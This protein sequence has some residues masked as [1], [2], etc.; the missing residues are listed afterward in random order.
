MSY[1]PPADTLSVSW[2][3]AQEYA[4]PQSGL[5]PSWGTTPVLGA[6]GIAPPAMPQ[7]G[8]RLA[9]QFAADVSVA[10]S[11]S[12]VG[13]AHIGPPDAYVRPQN[14]LGG[15]WFGA[16]A[17][18]PPVA[19]LQGTWALTTY[20][21]PPGI[22]EGDVSPPVL[23]WQQFVAPPGTDFTQFGGSYALHPWQYAPPEWTL[24][25]T[26]VGAGA[27]SPPAH[28][29]VNG[30]WAL[31]AESVYVSTVGW[32]S[33]VSGG[34]L[35][36]LATKY[37]SPAGIPPGTFGALVFANGS[38]GISIGG[39]NAG[40]IGAPWVSFRT[41][42]LTPNG[43]A[44]PATQTPSPIVTPEV[45]ILDLAGRGIASLATGTAAVTHKVREV[46]P[47]FIAQGGFGSHLIA[48]N[49]VVE[50]AGWESSQPGTAHSV[51]INLQRVEPDSGVS[52]P[53]GYGGTHV[54]NQHEVVYPQGWASAQ[55]NAH[56]VYNQTQSVVVGPFA[57]NLPPTQW[58]HY[59][60]YVENRHR[61]LAPSGWSSSK[62]SLIGTLI[63]NGAVPI[64][65]DG[66]DATLWGSGTFIAHRVRTV[67]TEG[68]EEFYAPRYTAVYNS[69]ALLRLVGIGST[70]ACG[71]PT[72]ANLNRTVG[73]F[74]PSGPEEVGTPTIDFA[75]RTLHPGEFFQL[76]SGI[77]EVR[78]NP[79]PIAPI[80][81]TPE[82]Q[83]GSANVIERF[84]T[85]APSSANVHPVPWVGE[86]F[87]QNRNK[88]LVVPPTFGMEFG[89][90]SVFNYIRTV[91]VVGI[92]PA[93]FGPTTNIARRTKELRPSAISLPTFSVTHQ[94]R[95]VI[96]DLPAQQYVICTGLYSSAVP[97]PHVAETNLHPDGIEP[98]GFG[99]ATVSRNSIDVLVGIY[100]YGK[101][102]TPRMIATQYVYPKI[103]PWPNSGDLEHPLGSSDLNDSMARVTPHTIY[104]PSSDQAT[105]QA[106]ANHPAPGSPHVVDHELSLYHG[107]WSKDNGWPFFGRPDISNQYRS[108]GP[109]PDHGSNSLSPSSRFANPT[110]T[111]RRQYI[112]PVGSRMQRFGLVV[113]RDV[114]QYIDFDVSSGGKPS[115]LVFGT[116][117]AAHVV[118]YSPNLYPDGVEGGEVGEHE[119]QLRT[120]EISPQGI[121]HRGNP[122][123][124]LT[125]PWGAPLI[126]YPRVYA[127]GGY[128]FTLFGTAWISHK[129]REL[130]TEGWQ[131]DTL[132]VWDNSNFET[133]MRVRF[134]TLSAY[135][136]SHDSGELGQPVVTFGTR[137]LSVAPIL[138]P[139][140]AA[141]TVAQS[142]AAA[143]WLDTVF[144]DIDRWEENKIKPYGPDVS[145]F[146]T[147]RTARSVSA[148][149][150][151]I[152]AVSEPRVAFV[153]SPLG[154]PEIAF[155][156]PALFD[157][158]GC[159]SRVVAAFPVVSTQV[160]PTPTVTA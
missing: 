81:F 150:V 133:R 63:E 50:P 103:I 57:D 9:A 28:D 56:L 89:N 132:G 76:S 17:Y 125:N 115:S 111:L 112:Y 20:I 149:G 41:R 73:Q 99:T 146:G 105:P 13:S 116:H 42:T 85:A 5:A 84:T 80:G 19:N 74:F 14:V 83:F 100:E 2:V 54:R 159:N 138:P 124:G 44:T 87:V 70:S 98:V 43:I 97:G 136:H 129:N 8:V 114:P 77:P 135:Q 123:Q 26:W 66:L 86:P 109:A 144:G 88:T 27:Y 31:P 64:S 36:D 151:L 157:Q 119:V 30:Q 140:A 24:T 130:P 78:H 62:F 7:P 25:A 48:R 49:T 108:I 139:N 118:P 37:I 96:P 33:S 104:A 113:F 148:T 3:G 71:V 93:A 117:S 122:Q 94:I 16:D 52:D 32:A 46:A 1:T 60:P 143:G 39:I 142:V 152:T 45:Q 58:P 18:A 91:F 158:N 75:V 101:F 120:R 59:A 102:G 145:A 128:G 29:A 15:S 92:A 134:G 79:Y 110:V 61:T 23:V 47:T 155:A 69:A 22:F 38:L 65:P 82:Y 12:V 6:G 141:P 51:D 95:N 53:A 107:Q 10:A 4:K 68:W 121:P 21:S 90:P 11:G 40:A 154:L 160:V 127:L 67:Y 131:S 153:I 137:Y 126:G 106:N 147:P 34:H 35:V 72:L 156:G 55:I